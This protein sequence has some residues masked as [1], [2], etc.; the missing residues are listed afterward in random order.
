MGRALRGH[1]LCPGA[2]WHPG[3]FSSPQNGEWGAGWSQGLGPRGGAG[4][5]ERAPQGGQGRL[6]PLVGLGNGVSGRVPRAWA[7]GGQA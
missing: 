4:N 7:P 1:R 6:G 3:Q 5:W 2:R